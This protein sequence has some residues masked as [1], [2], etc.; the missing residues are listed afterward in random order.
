MRGGALPLGVIQSAVYK[1]AASSFSFSGCVS[2]D[3]G[4]NLDSQS[5]GFT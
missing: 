3:R 2:E 5:L 4:L 1:T